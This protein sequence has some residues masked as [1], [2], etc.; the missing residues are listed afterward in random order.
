MLPTYRTKISQF[1]SG[2]IVATAV[3][4]PAMSFAQFPK[5][6]P[7]PFDDHKEMMKILGI[8]AIRGGATP[9]GPNADDEVTANKYLGTV[10]DVFL[11]NNGSYVTKAAQWASRRRELVEIFERDIYGRVP[12]NAPKVSW[13]VTGITPGMS[14][15]TPTITK[16]L[17]GHVD[18]R[19]YPSLKV[20]IQASFTVP[21]NAIQKVPI[22]IEFGF[23]MGFGGGLPTAAKPWTMDGATGRLFLPRSNRI[24]I[25][26]NLA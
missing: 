19:A 6:P 13:E 18:N 4:L 24:A 10:P 25:M 7:P 14:G 26:W 23:G 3:V 21:A 12:K 20:N 11:M 9:N 16:T 17:I 15:S 22:M 1:A 8:R 5:T 2:L